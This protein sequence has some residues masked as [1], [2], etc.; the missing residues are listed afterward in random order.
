ML[1]VWGG[2]DQRSGKCSRVIVCA[3]SQ[4][5]AVALLEK[6]GVY[7]ITLSILRNYW[8]HTANEIE[9]SVATE[10]GVWESEKQYYSKAED[11]KRLV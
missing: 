9:L 11:F 3:K 7:R 8:S 4:K 2:L 5:D 10:A 6:A 1:K